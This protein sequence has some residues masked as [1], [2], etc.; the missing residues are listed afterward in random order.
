MFTLRCQCG[1]KE[2]LS[3][4]ILILEMEAQVINSFKFLPEDFFYQNETVLSKRKHKIGLEVWWNDAGFIHFDGS[5]KVTFTLQR[6]RQF[7]LIK[8]ISTLEM[9]IMMTNGGVHHKLQ[10]PQQ[11]EQG[12]RFIHTV[13][14][15]ARSTL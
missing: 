13:V 15:M 7:F 9:G 6:Q 11:C 8:W 1:W 5:F 12:F 14:A 10:L 2:F 3:A 4:L